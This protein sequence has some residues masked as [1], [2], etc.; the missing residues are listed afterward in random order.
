MPKD[1]QTI[2]ASVRNPETG[3]HEEKEIPLDVW[4][5]DPA[6]DSRVMY[7][8]VK[9][10]DLCKEHIFNKNHECT[11]C[12]FVFVGFRANMHIQNGGIFERKPGNKLGARLA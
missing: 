4:T 8:R 6:D 3:R 9:D 12:P 11:R 5:K 1:T 10:V 2:T 7:T